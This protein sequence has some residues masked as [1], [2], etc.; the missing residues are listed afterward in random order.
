[1]V[2]TNCNKLLQ[3]TFFTVPTDRV[4]ETVLQGSPGAPIGLFDQLVASAHPIRV[5]DLA[6]LARAQNRRSSRDKASQAV[7]AGRTV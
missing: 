2:V 6:N 1:M 4:G 5:T 7:D 3:A